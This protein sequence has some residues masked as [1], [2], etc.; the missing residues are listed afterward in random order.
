[1]VNLRTTQHLVQTQSNKIEHFI[2]SAYRSEL[3]TIGPLDNKR[4]ALPKWRYIP[5]WAASPV[6]N[7]KMHTHTHNKGPWLLSHTLHAAQPYRNQP[8]NCWLQSKTIFVW[9]EKQKS[10]YTK[11]TIGHWMCLPSEKK[12]VRTYRFVSRIRAILDAK[13]LITI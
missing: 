3:Y 8:S 13:R 4:K 9:P 7:K 11:T 12:N 2:Y 6:L 10:M 1:M 5:I